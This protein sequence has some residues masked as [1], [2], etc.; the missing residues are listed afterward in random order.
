M[1]W[2]FYVFLGCDEWWPFCAFVLWFNRCTSYHEMCWGDR[3]L[4]CPCG[5]SSGCP[6]A[7]WTGSCSSPLG[8]CSATRPGWAWTGRRW[9]PLS[10][11]AWTARLQYWMSGRWQKSK[12]ETLR[13]LGAI[14]FPSHIPFSYWTPTELALCLSV[15]LL[16]AKIWMDPIIFYRWIVIVCSVNE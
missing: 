7:L 8:S 1:N 14:I 5:C 9:A 15:S 13:Y 3:L 6:C 16:Q 2:T 11:R 4:G 12:V 10:S